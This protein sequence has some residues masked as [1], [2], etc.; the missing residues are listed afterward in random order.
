MATRKKVIN[1]SK[2][3]K[4]GKKRNGNKNKNIININVNSNNKKIGGGG[5]NRG[6][7][8]GGG[9]SF[10]PDKKKDVYIP[11]YLPNPVINPIPP[12]DKDKEKE[13]KD[14]TTNLLIGYVK[15]SNLLLENAFEERIK[16]N[17]LSIKSDIN[18]STTT[19]NNYLYNDINKLHA[20]L[21]LKKDESKLVEDVNNPDVVD[22]DYASAKIDIDEQ[23]INKDVENNE[24]IE[25]IGENYDAVN[26]E[27]VNNEAVN[28][29]VVNNEQFESIGDNKHTSLFT[30][31]LN[32][33]LNKNDNMSVDGSDFYSIH[34]S[35]TPQ[36][37]KS[38]YMENPN[39]IDHSVFADYI[40]E[41]K[42]DEINNKK[43]DMFNFFDNI[44]YRE[45][46]NP[47][48]V[49]TNKSSKIKNKKIESEPVEQKIELVEQKIE[50][51][52]QKVE[53]MQQKKKIIQ[54]KIIEEDNNDEKPSK[55]RYDAFM[56]SLQS[57]DKLTPLK[58]EDK[59]IYQQLMGNKNKSKIN[60]EGAINKIRI[61]RQLL[62]PD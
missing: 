26:N 62:Y 23:N 7:N 6:G 4:K 55:G 11:P 46:N 44:L 33:P 45:S 53:P 20:L 24:L 18:N 9:K 38:Q 42:K 35:Y 3:D 39:Q 47:P 48:V 32:T 21:D 36:I 1:K 51:V 59:I 61:K 13:N 22:G 49:T 5:N 16:Q 15:N 40:P 8:N 43:N 50:P 2:K 28:N 31:W 30:A 27:A 14:E 54:K 19:N 17:N 29:D 25:S 37:K 12:K 34:S 57:Y 58:K 41:N 56:N 60:A 10:A 52:Q